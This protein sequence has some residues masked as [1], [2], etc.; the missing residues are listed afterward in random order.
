ME[1]RTQGQKK[2]SRKKIDLSR[3]NQNLEEIFAVTLDAVLVIKDQEFVECNEATV[4][5]LKAKDR[6]Q[7]LNTHPSELSPEFQPCGKESFVKANE[8]IAIAFERGFNRFEWIHRRFDGEDFPVEVSLVGIESDVDGKLLFTLWRDLTAEKRA[9]R[10]L[11]HHSKLAS[12]G[13]LA[14]GVGHEIN[15]PLAIL[16]GNLERLKKKIAEYQ[17][18]PEKLEKEISNIQE[19]SERI[20]R[21]VDGLRVYSRADNDR[22]DVVSLNEALEQTMNLVSE[23][24]KNEGIDL[25]VVDTPIQFCVRGQL[26]NL[27]QVIMNLLSNAKDAVENST[28]K[29]IQVTLTEADNGR[30]RLTIKDSGVGIPLEIQDKILNPFFTTKEVG[31]G[32]GLGLSFVSEHVSEMGGSLSV[33]SVPGQGSE[34]TVELPL[35]RGCQG[36]DCRKFPRFKNSPSHYQI[37]G[38]ALV[39]DDESQIREILSEYLEEL[40]LEVFEAKNGEDALRMI[41]EQE[42][43]FIFSDFHMPGLN[44]DRL[45]AEAK[46]YLSE[47]TKLILVTGGVSLPELREEDSQLTVYEV[48]KKPFTKE[49]VVQAIKSC[50]QN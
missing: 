31:R 44:G 6:D 2:S 13:Q 7:V 3:I 17:G 38:K 34:F 14:A 10:E 29:E 27:Q 43:H 41:Q 42:F 21:I 50:T 12:I 1:T 37:S 18:A 24:Y 48:I 30:V 19:A 22:V 8:M 20:R 33:K 26:G 15:N 11:V 25:K 45:F 9:N 46:P 28:I 23:I 5:M 39:I 36:E 40:G 49:S 47:L 4:R 32:T 35:D 16:N